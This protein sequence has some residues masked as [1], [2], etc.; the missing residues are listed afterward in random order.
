[1]GIQIKR[2]HMPFAEQIFEH[3]IKGFP[4]RHVYMINSMCLTSCVRATLYVEVF[5]SINER[6]DTP[7]AINDL[8]I[9]LVEKLPSL[10]G[11]YGLLYLHAI[12][13]SL[14]ADG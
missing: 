10:K 12:R 3:F 7:H 4:E 6:I 8:Q 13:L 9:T 11:K 14:S 1:M 2:E 5:Y